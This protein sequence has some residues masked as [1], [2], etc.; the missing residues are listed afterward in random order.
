MMQKIVVMDGKRYAE[1][2]G[3]MVPEELTSDYMYRINPNRDA[4]IEEERKAHRATIP[5][6]IEPENKK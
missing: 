1:I 6:W 4:E 3:C 5:G 2:G